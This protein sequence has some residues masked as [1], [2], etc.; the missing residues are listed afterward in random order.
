MV[1]LLE[2]VNIVLA[3]DSSRDHIAGLVEQ[4]KSATAS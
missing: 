2:P 1:Y 3:S 4:T